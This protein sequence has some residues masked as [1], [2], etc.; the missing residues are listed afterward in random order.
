MAPFFPV[1]KVLPKQDLMKP[2][3]QPKP[4]IWLRICQMELHLSLQ[5]LPQEKKNILPTSFS[6]F[7]SRRQEELY[8]TERL[9][10]SCKYW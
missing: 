7:A 10:T 4:Q 6:V 3:Q 5:Q 1:K 2:Y 9:K 8:R